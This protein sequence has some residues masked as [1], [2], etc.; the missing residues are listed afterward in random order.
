VG[1]QCA[2][3]GRTLAQ[4]RD[5]YSSYA[6]AFGSVTR[7]QQG[8][9]GLG[10]LDEQLSRLTATH[11]KVCARVGAFD[12]RLRALEQIMEDQDSPSAKLLLLALGGQE[13]VLGRGEEAS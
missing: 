4:M 13:D 9:A 11:A 6:G 3:R 2:E 10:G 1:V 5:F 7:K 8:A 12:G